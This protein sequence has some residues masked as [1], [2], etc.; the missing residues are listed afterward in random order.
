MQA[1]AGSL[2]RVGQ[3]ETIAK[4][5]STRFGPQSSAGHTHRCSQHSRPI[6]RALATTEGIRGERMWSTVNRTRES[7]VGKV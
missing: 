7:V 4:R 6:R 1:D 2:R 5:Y 3:R